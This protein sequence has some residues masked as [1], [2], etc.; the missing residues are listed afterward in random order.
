MFSITL[1]IGNSSIPWTLLFK[2]EESFAPAKKAV[3]SI[4][5]EGGGCIIE[6]DFGQTVQAGDSIIQGVMFEDLDKSKLAHIAF[7][8]HRS[9][10]Q[11]ETQKAAETDPALRQARMMQGSPVISP[12]GNGGIPFTGR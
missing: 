1:V 6:D 4:M 11:V 5:S 12:M 8:L 10:M 7:S 3:Q 2:T 9:R